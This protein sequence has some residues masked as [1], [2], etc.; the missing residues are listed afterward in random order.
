MKIIFKMIIAKH[1]QINKA[2]IHWEAKTEKE[3]K[4]FRIEIEI[5]K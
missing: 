5:N 4:R 2:K 3:G 1:A